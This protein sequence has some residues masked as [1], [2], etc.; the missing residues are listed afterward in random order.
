[1][2]T[3]EIAN[4]EQL[5]GNTVILV[6]TLDRETWHTQ[7]DLELRAAPSRFVAS[8]SLPNEVRDP[9]AIR[10]LIADNQSLLSRSVAELVRDSG[11]DWVT[12][13]RQQL[14]RISHHTQQK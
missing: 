13:S 10:I 9:T 2:F 12:T 6:L 8:S 11:E 5:N 7:T 3:P 14:T 4:P 1:V